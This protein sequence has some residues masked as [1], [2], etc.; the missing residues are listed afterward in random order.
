MSTTFDHPGWKKSLLKGI[1]QAV[2]EARALARQNGEYAFARSRVAPEFSGIPEPS[3][4]YRP[5]GMDYATVSFE[6]GTARLTWP[7]KRQRSVFQFIELDA[8]V[9]DDATIH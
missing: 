7:W 5:V 6:N 9:I 3:N 2:G 1:D 4:F 8:G